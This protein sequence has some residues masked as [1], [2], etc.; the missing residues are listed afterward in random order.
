MILANL[1]SRHVQAIQLLLEGELKDKEIAQQLGVRP[2]TLAKWKASPV[3]QQRYQLERGIWEEDLRDIRLASPKR[4]LQEA[5]A[6]HDWLEKIKTQSENAAQGAAVMKAKGFLRK[7]IV[8]ELSRFELARL[9]QPHL[10]DTQSPD[11]ARAVEEAVFTDADR[12][13][14]ERLRAFA[15]YVR[16][17][18][19]QRQ[20]MGATV[21]Q[22]VN[23]LDLMATGKPCRIEDRGW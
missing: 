19:A 23:D 15:G 22:F 13:D 1:Q 11:S 18:A 8:E 6:D 2:D 12:T 21:E 9:T 10:P 4:R 20:A 16:M 17:L 7:D 14:A 3:F 5:Q